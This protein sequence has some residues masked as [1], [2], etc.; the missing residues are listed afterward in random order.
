MLLCGLMTRKQKLSLDETVAEL[1]RKSEQKISSI[2][3]SITDCH[4]E[5]DKDW[6]FIRINDHS[7]AYFGRQRGELIGQSYFEVFPTLKG[8]VFEE[9][10]NKAVSKSTSVHFHVASVIYSGKWVEL[11]VYPTEGRGVSVF[12][13]DITKR[14]LADEETKRLA[15]VIQEERDRLSALVNSIQDEVWFADAEGKFT[16]ANPSA[17]REFSIGVSTKEIDVEKLAQSLEV[18]RADGTPRPIEETPPL[19]ALQGEVVRNQEEMIRTPAGAELRYRVISAAP[20]RDAANT[21]I[22][23]VSVVRDITDLKRAEI[24]L[25]ESEE[26]FRAFMDNNPAIAW[27][28]DEQGRIIY[29]NRAYEQRFGVRL[30]DWRGKT[31]FELWPPEI[32]RTFR[33]NDLDVLSAGQTQEMVE[34]ATDPDGTHSFWWNFKFPFQDA[35]GHHYVGGIGIDITDRKRIEKQLK[36]YQEHLEK[37]VEERTKELRMKSLSLEEVN[38][39]LKVLLEQREKDKNEL[40]DKIL[41]NVRKLILPYIDSLRQ[42]RLD[43]EQRTYL[44]ILETNLK[45]I[46]SPFAKKLT[47][48]QD[49]FTPL[50]IKVADFIR[51]GKTA[52]EIANTFGVSESAINLHRQHIRN[53]L[54]LNNKKINLTTYLLSLTY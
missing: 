35:S 21:I 43:D 15:T 14:K 3:A 36:D 32:A 9:Q 11:H 12:F 31:D 37:L 29:L 49:N 20:V 18:Y 46:I 24:A 27:A 51:D 5:L 2:L 50:E 41:F 34:E 10:Y 48:I 45:N 6:R 26:R 47:S 16:L 53:K 19:R 23:S 13:R 40:E 44:D 30:E 42:R 8:S 17:L 7:L 25:R 54:G 22:G 38:I 1:S 52:K 28:K 39:A 33:R 4:F